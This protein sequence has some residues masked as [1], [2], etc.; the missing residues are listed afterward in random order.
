VILRFAND[1]A[2]FDAVFEEGA[3]KVAITPEQS[4]EWDIGPARAA[5]LVEKDGERVFERVFLWET[6]VEILPSPLEPKTESKWEKE[7]RMVEEAIE[8]VLK[9]KGVQ[10][11]QIQ[12][13]AGTRRVERMTLEELRKA[14]NFLEGRV[15][16]ERRRQGVRGGRSNW[17]K[18]G[19][20]FND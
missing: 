20:K 11:Y 9:G 7:L 5:A 13:I 4:R 14:R 16:A 19:A 2:D 6:E 1:A 15:A 10:S 18:I 3:W 8:G 17:R 12:T